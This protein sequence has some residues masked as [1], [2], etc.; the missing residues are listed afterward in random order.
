MVHVVV[1][2]S[3]ADCEVMGGS[4]FFTLDPGKKKPLSSTPHYERIVEKLPRRAD[5]SLPVG[6]YLSLSFFLLLPLK[7]GCF[8]LRYTNWRSSRVSPFTKTPVLWTL[9]AFSG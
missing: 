7:G 1:C 9:S 8:N 5:L 2:T 3:E 6:T 4:L